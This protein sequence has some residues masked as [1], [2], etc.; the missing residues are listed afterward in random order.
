MRTRPGWDAGCTRAPAPRPLIRGEPGELPL[1]PPYPLRSV[2]VT[3]G[4]SPEAPLQR[5]IVIVATVARG[6]GGGRGL[7]TRVA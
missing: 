7:V 3:S 1:P 5:V 2:I 4:R 6:D